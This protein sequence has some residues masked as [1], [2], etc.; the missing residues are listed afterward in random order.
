MVSLAL[1]KINVNIGGVVIENGILKRGQ[2]SKKCVGCVEHGL[3]HIMCNDLGG[4]KCADHIF[5]LQ[6]VASEYLMIRGATVGIADVTPSEE[7]YRE[8]RT[9]MESYLE[10]AQ[11]AANTGTAKGWKQFYSLLDE[12]TT[13]SGQIA[14]KSMSG[15]SNGLK[16]EI[17]SG[18][19]GSLLNQTQ[20][21]ATLGMQYINGGPVKINRNDR[22]LSHFEPE[23]TEPRAR[24]YVDNSFIHGIHPAE[25]WFHATAGRIGLI[26]TAVGTSESGYLQRRLAKSMCDFRATTDGTVRNSQK[27]IVQ[28]KYGSNGFDA[29]HEEHQYFTKVGDSLREFEDY[30]KFPTTTSS[31][32]SGEFSSLLDARERLGRCGLTTKVVIPIPVDRMI[33][34]LQQQ[35]AR[36]EVVVD[37]SVTSSQSKRARITSDSKEI[38]IAEEV[39]EIVKKLLER[40]VEHGEYETSTFLDSLRIFLASKSLVHRKKLTPKFVSLLCERIFTSY[41]HSLVQGGEAVGSLASQSM[42]E[43]STQMTLNTFHTTGSKHLGVSMG[44]PRMKEILNCAK[45]IKTP[46]MRVH[47]R[48]PYNTKEFAEK[49]AKMYRS[50]NVSKLVSNFQIIHEPQCDETTIVQDQCWLRDHYI[51]HPD[52]KKKQNLFSRIVVRIV[53]IKSELTNSFWTIRSLLEILS[54]R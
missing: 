13:M 25:Y 3:V 1:P 32:L 35:I 37:D 4:M 48:P 38:V 54:E 51:L 46:I 11:A 41:E 33:V 40:M 24:G 16:N 44:V 49:F 27:N 7:T 23:S 14:L 2:L 15:C 10:R 19:K 28:F 47:L 8:I 42:G 39:V 53:M 21:I 52:E 50:V 26:D 17:D 45:S 31:I 5:I 43:P 29:V 34:N 22:V 9:L 6:K 12:A 20:T 18:A 30:Y 36:K